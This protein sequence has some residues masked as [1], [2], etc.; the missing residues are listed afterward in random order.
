MFIVCQV[1]PKI[2]GNCMKQL[3]IVAV[4]AVGNW[5]AQNTDA[6]YYLHSLEIEKHWT[7]YCCLNLE[8]DM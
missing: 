8:K 5:M 1:H 7:F 2:W 4:E 3:T 6:W